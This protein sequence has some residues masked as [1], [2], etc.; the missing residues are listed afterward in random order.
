M[1]YT[2][3]KQRHSSGHKSLSQY[4]PGYDR[5][6]TRQKND[7]TGGRNVKGKVVPVLFF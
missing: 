3:A 1:N 4:K 5:L 7:K 6:T 2:V